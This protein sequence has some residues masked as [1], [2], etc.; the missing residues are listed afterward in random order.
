MRNNNGRMVIFVTVLVAV[1]LLGSCQL[2]YDP[3]NQMTIDGS[4]YPLSRM[5]VYEHSDLEGVLTVVITS[6]GLNVGG[7]Q[8]ET[9]SGKGDFLAVTLASESGS[10]ETGIYE[11]KAASPP[12]IVP[13]FSYAV[14]GF[15]ADRDEV[16]EGYLVGGGSIVVRTIIGGGYSIHVELRGGTEE[17]LNTDDPP[18][19]WVWPTSTPI[20]AT[21]RG[22]VTDTFTGPFFG[23]SG[24]RI[25]ARNW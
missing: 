20:I 10:L 14:V 8:G 17:E 16:D 1:T 4:K 21:F 23:S 12:A 13:L 3:F 2:L 15:D 18:E 5:Y 24:S 11:F 19:D 25:G 7:S 6:K 9:F 22:H